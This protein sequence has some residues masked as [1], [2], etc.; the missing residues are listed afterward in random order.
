[1]N[2]FHDRKDESPRQ[3]HEQINKGRTY[4]EIFG[5]PFLIVDKGQ[6]VEDYQAKKRCPAN[7]AEHIQT[8]MLQDIRRP[9]RAQHGQSQQSSNKDVVFSSFATDGIDGMSDAAGAIADAHTLMRAHKKSLDPN[10]F[11]DENNSYEFFK[12]LGDLFT[13]G[14]TGTNVMDIQI[15]VKIR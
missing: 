6:H 7:V 13:T 3:G 1:M 11:L 2:C 14:P 15:L 5:D 8:G 4:N 9:D 10:K 12:N